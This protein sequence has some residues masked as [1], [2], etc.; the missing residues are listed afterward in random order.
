MR[1]NSR[2]TP[3]Q[4]KDAADLEH[5]RIDQANAQQ[6]TAAELEAAVTLDDGRLAVVRGKRL[7][8]IATE[9]RSIPT[10]SADLPQIKENTPRKQRAPRFIVL[11]IETREISFSQ[12]TAQE[13][14]ELRAVTADYRRLAS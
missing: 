12:L 7:I 1:S 5:R 13:L 3:R 11:D 8:P 4:L 14:A 2:L 6:R 9:R 10:S